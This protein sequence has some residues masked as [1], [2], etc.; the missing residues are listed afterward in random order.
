MLQGI[1]GPE[2]IHFVPSGINAGKLMVNSWTG[3]E[4]LLYDWP[5]TSP[6]ALPQRF[7]A[8]TSP[9]G[10]DFDP[11]TGDLFFSAIEPVT[12]ASGIY[13]VANCQ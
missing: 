4:I 6:T 3:G 11:I 13:H 2:G 7:A 5:P 8:L 12:V 9:Y 10:V 1:S